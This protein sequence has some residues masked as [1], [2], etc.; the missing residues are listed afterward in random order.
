MNSKPLR[1]VILPI[2][3]AT[4]IGYALVYGWIE[5]RRVRQ[6]PWRVTFG[7]VSNGVP[8]LII[9]QPALGITN[10]QVVFAG[11]ALALPK[12]PETLAFANAR[13][14]P[15]DVPFGQCVFQDTTFLPGTVVFKSF[16]HEIQLLPRVLTLN[17]V[18]R[19]WRANEIITLTNSPPLPG[20]P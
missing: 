10:V 6:G 11:Y 15:F 18:E 4:I 20:T 19:P 13:P 8:E 12:A 14:V 1:R 9:N 17:R 3:A 5:N 2:L 7:F 16:G